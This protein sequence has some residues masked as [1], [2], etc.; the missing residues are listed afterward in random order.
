L[1]ETKPTFRFGIPEGDGVA[2]RVRQ[3]LDDRIARGLVTPQEIERVAALRLR[4]FR[5][6]GFAAEALRG[7]AINWEANRLPP[8][9]SHR[10][11]VGAF[12][13]PVK[14]ALRRIFRHQ[15][16]TFLDRQATFNWN[17]ML[18]LREVIDEL[19]RLKKP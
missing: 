7:C 14:K 6:D 1:S 17:L 5:A 10:A 16:D 11:I 15:Y 19:D 4:L 18:V 2:A 13:V 8:I 9:T 12:L 3:R